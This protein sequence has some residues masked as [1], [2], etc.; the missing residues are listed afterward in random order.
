MPHCVCGVT[1]APQLWMCCARSVVVALRPRHHNKA[2]VISSLSLKLSCAE[3]AAACAP[4]PLAF[5]LQTPAALARGLHT[6]RTIVDGKCGTDSCPLQGP[7][8][9]PRTFAD[10]CGKY[11]GT[12]RACTRRQVMADLDCLRQ[13]TAVIP[14][15]AFRACG[16]RLQAFRAWL[17]CGVS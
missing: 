3:P 5:A 14:R 9:D 6:Y 10:A 7:I 15:L 4:F 16:S 11:A 17:T 12:V 8:L 13:L 1:P 2:L